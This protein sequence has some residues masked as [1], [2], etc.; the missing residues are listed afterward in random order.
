ML[1]VQIDMYMYRYM[2][3]KIFIGICICKLNM[4]FEEWVKYVIEICMILLFYFKSLG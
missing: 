3:V 1:Y 2:K 4:D